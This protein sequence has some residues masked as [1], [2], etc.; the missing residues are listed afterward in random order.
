MTVDT[1]NRDPN[2]YEIKVCDLYENK[3][4]GSLQIENDRMN[5]ESRLTSK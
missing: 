3:G 2:K 5:R 4:L 1:I